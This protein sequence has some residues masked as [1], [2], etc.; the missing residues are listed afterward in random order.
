M[1]PS[2]LKRKKKKV[3]SNDSLNLTINVPCCGKQARIPE[4]GHNQGSVYF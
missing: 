2:F 1:T 4:E 3:T